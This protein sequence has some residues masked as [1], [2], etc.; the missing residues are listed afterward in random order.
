MAS[1]SRGT[2]C[3]KAILV[4][5]F[6]LSFSVFYF[7]LILTRLFSVL[8]S[9]HYVFLV[10]SIALLGLGLGGVVF[11]FF[12]IKRTYLKLI[13]E[14]FYIFFSISIPISF[15]LILKLSEFPS[16]HSN[17]LFFALVVIGP[18][19]LAGGIFAEVFYLYSPHISKLYGIDLMGA[20][21]G[22]LSILFFLKL[23]GGE[24]SVIL[25]GVV[26]SGAASLLVLSR[27]N[28]ERKRFFTFLSLIILSINLGIFLIVLKIPDLIRLPL[29]QNPEKQSYV[30]LKKGDSQGEIVETRWSSF[31]RTD[32]VRLPKLP[33]LMIVYLD[34][35]AGSPML[36]FNGNLKKIS[37]IVR[38]LIINTPSFFPFFFLSL[39][40]K[41]NLLCIGA[42]GGRDVLLALV[43]R[44]KE[45]EAVEVN[46]DIVEITN[47]YAWYNGGIYSYSN[48]VRLQLEEGR[49]YL[50]RQ[51]KHYDLI[52]INFPYTKS[53]RSGDGLILT[54]NF[55]FT[56]KAIEDY[57]NHLTSEGR[58]IVACDEPLEVMRLLTTSLT[59]LSKR[60]INEKEALTRIYILGSRKKKNLFVLKKNP[61]QLEEMVKRQVYLEKLGFELKL[62]YLPFINSHFMPELV[63]LAEGKITLAS[64]QEK[65]RKCGLNISPVTDNRPFF[66]NFYSHLPP[67]LI[68]IFLVA[69]IL[70]IL[71]IIGPLIYIWAKN[72]RR[73][74]FSEF[75]R[76]RL[77]SS[78]KYI[79]VF[80]LLGMGY[81][82]IEISLIQKFILFLGQPGISINVIL[83]ALIIGSGLGSIIVSQNYFK[84]RKYLIFIICL[85]ICGL[86]ISYNF[87]LSY[88]FNLFM[89]IDFKLRIVLATSTVGLLGIFM[90]MLFPL[91]MN[92]LRRNKIESSI[93][94][95]YGLNAVSSVFGSIITM[96]IS[97]SF[98]FREA[99]IGGTFCYLIILVF[100][101]NE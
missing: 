82:L 24:V 90:G 101:R 57:L 73:K 56:D 4:G 70:L 20:A 79:V 98:G 65:Y 19:F 11:H 66:Y 88:I 31:G 12:V 5:I 95:M 72:Y 83:F 62:S 15:F 59:V 84:I 34:G 54:E 48:N 32:L 64:L 33:E 25:A 94:W 68:L 61:F 51:T 93:P 13:H 7:E 50:K 81:M 46:P 45:I 63:N 8:L 16:A 69:L 1:V 96:I 58:L 74:L 77:L 14:Y 10:V 41:D 55:L 29:G 47:K 86:G 30:V 49:N 99:L 85:I 35:T 42:G 2:K 9:Y 52:M 23:L 75:L 22:A 44:V 76:E 27:R 37:P 97:L 36:R 40:E 21:I 26:A 100:S 3:P 87:F 80:I 91:W 18:F 53:S 43:G 39:E 71:S 17:I 67:Q 38:N 6:F 78:L 60:G 92:Q 89:G 28:R